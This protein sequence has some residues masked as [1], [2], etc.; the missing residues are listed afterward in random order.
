MADK[1]REIQKI[2]PDICSG[3]D[4]A[5]ASEILNK[6][7]QE[8]TQFNDLWQ[9]LQNYLNDPA[10]AALFNRFPEARNIIESKV[11]EIKRIVDA[12]DAEVHEKE[13]SYDCSTKTCDKEERSGPFIRKYR[14]TGDEGTSFHN[15]ED[16]KVHQDSNSICG[17]GGGPGC[18]RKKENGEWEPIYSSADETRSSAGGAASQ[19]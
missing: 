8:R 9:E 2:C 7:K 6:I 12:I 16:D 15:T 17:Q 3:N 18:F 13:K 4:E 14:N 1:M 19:T 10:N 5:R 11:E